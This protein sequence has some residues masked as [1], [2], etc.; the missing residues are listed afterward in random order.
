MVGGL[1]AD[2][3]ALDNVLNLSGSSGTGASGTQYNYT[4]VHG[5]YVYAESETVSGVSR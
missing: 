1:T 5:R 3:R 4:V 2:V